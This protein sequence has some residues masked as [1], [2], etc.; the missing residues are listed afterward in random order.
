MKLIA[1][2][3]ISGEIFK[4]IDEADEKLILVSPYIDFKNWPKLTSRLKAAL[5]RNVK[6]KV[7]IRDGQKNIKSLNEL[8]AF[9][10]NPCLVPYLHAKLYF[11]EKDAVISSMNL[12]NSSDQ[13][14]LEIAHKIE[15]E[16][17]YNEIAEYYKRYIQSFGDNQSSNMTTL[18]SEIFYR[19]QTYIPKIKIYSG[20][21]SVTIN[22]RSNK[23]HASII[24]YHGSHYLKISVPLSYDQFT[25]Q[26]LFQSKFK[27]PADLKIEFVNGKKGYYDLAIGNLEKPLDSKHISDVLQTEK[28]MIANA[29]CMFISKIEDFKSLVY[30]NQKS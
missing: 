20:H 21:N 9:G 25:Q 1:P 7:Y 26:K 4:L 24:N 6:V 11:N 23:F 19:L 8:Q 5:N 14:S 29:I 13:Y 3:K 16:N 22:T 10:I 27:L 15:S 28:S 12:L 17:E 18:E 2:S 30:E